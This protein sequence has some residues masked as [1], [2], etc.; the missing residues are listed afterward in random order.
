[1][2]PIRPIHPIPPNVLD[3]AGADDSNPKPRGKEFLGPEPIKIVFELFIYS[4]FGVD[5]EAADERVCGRD[6]AVWRDPIYFFGLYTI[7]SL[8][9]DKICG[10]CGIWREFDKKSC[11]NGFDVGNFRDYTDWV[12]LSVF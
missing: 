10:A 5:C 11:F 4:D 2:D 9:A 1:M 8:F 7:G 3:T 12:H 6:G